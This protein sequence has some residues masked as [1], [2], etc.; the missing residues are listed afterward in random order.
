MTLLTRNE[1]KRIR[2]AE[3]PEYREKLRVENAE[4]KLWH[5]YGLSQADYDFMVVAQNG[6]CAICERKPDS[7][8]C[9]DHCHATR[10]LR[11]LLCHKCNAG[12]GHFDDD[13]RLLRRAADYAEFW[14]RVLAAGIA[15]RLVPERKP[16][17][18]RARGDR[19][20]E[21]A[22]RCASGTTAER[23]GQPVGWVERS[24]RETQHPRAIVVGSRKSSTQ[25]TDVAAAERCPAVPVSQVLGARKVGQ[26][27]AYQQHR[28]ASVTLSAPET[29]AAVSLSHSLVSRDSGT[30]PE[31]ACRRPAPP[32]ELPSDGTLHPDALGQHS[33]LANK[34]FRS[35]S[36]CPTPR[37]RKARQPTAQLQP[38]PQKRR[39]A[40]P[41]TAPAVSPSH[42][43]VPRDSETP[44]L[45]DLLLPAP[46]KPA[47]NAG[48][49]AAV[50][51]GPGVDQLVRSCRTWT[52]IH[53]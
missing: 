49:T 51:V 53:G 6:L 40:A 28:S 26:P 13:P 42:F 9:V 20:A 25:P 34:D 19:P 23:A 41:G 44:P 16:G 30:P 15:V 48:I 38:R 5:N 35:L 37:A 11:F 36:R 14:Q 3:D 8:L 33:S 12:L 43:L 32:A 39:P 24:S 31:A 1:K 29:A 27:G 47:E 21:A 7:K 4:W 22:E 46:A 50:G 18:R 17:K 10:R 2:C 45:D 52:N